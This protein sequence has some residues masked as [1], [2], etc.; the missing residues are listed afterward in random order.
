MI[1][2]LAL[3]LL[4]ANA[5][6]GSVTLSWTPPTENEDATPYTDPAGY[7]IY[8]GTATGVYSDVI[9]VPDPLVTTYVVDNL[10]DGAYFFVSTAY[11]LAGTESQYSNEAT[12]TVVTIPNPPS[13]LTVV[14]TNLVA[15]AISQSKDRLVTYPVGSVPPGTPCDGSMTANG[16]YLVPF[17]AVTFAGSAR[18]AVVLAE[19][20]GG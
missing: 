8:Y 5:F 16:M 2:Y 13:N 19:C 10:V 14:Q 1:K 18:P 4:S 17:D 9:N 20:S 3:L 11:N 6:A 15:F 12:K 7:N